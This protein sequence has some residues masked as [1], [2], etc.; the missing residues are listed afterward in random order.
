MLSDRLFELAKAVEEKALAADEYQDGVS[1]YDHVPGVDFRDIKDDLL[2]L[3]EE[4]KAD[5]LFVVSKTISLRGPRRAVLFKFGLAL[6]QQF[7]ERFGIKEK[8]APGP[9]GPILDAISDL[10]GLDA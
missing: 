2:S 9:D 3:A 1:S 5:E 10:E 7:S 4:A 8:L 6:L